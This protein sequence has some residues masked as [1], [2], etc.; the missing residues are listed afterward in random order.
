MATASAF[1][2]VTSSGGGA[3]DLF[4]TASGLGPAGNLDTQSL[5][6]T[7]VG[8]TSPLAFS[9]KAVRPDGSNSTA[10]FD[11]AAIQNPTFTPS[12]VGLYTVTCTVSDDATHKLS[13]SHPQSAFVGTAL[14]GKITSSA[15]GAIDTTDFTTQELTASQ[16]GA[17]TGGESYVWEVLRPD[18][19]SGSTEYSSFST[20]PLSQ[21]C[22]FTPAQKGI[23]VHS[24]RMTD[25]SGEFVVLTALQDR[26]W[27][28]RILG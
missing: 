10:E 4:L 3:G 12:R 21:S 28:T 17:G 9:W 26:D 19:T 24:V 20:S 27:E 13:A 11:N 15:G 14:A 18:G 2:G 7:A 16:T 1:I 6:A 8:G 25:S 5:T 23:H 22:I